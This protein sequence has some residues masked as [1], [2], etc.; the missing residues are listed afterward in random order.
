MHTRESIFLLDF[1]G[2]HN[3]NDM[4]ALCF[5]A[6]LCSVLQA[7]A[8][9]SKQFASFKQFA[10][11]DRWDLDSMCR[12]ETISRHL[13]AT[14]GDATQAQV[15]K[16]V[17]DCLK[18]SEIKREEAVLR[19]TAPSRVAE[20]EQVDVSTSETHKGV[21]SASETH[22]GIVLS[23]TRDNGPVVVSEPPPTH[24]VPVTP[25]VIP[26][27]QMQHQVVGELPPNPPFVMPADSLH[28][29]QHHGG[30]HA[31][32]HVEMDEE[33]H[34]LNVVLSPPEGTPI[35]IT[36]TPEPGVPVPP[37]LLNEPVV[38]PVSTTLTNVGTL[39]PMPPIEVT[40]PH[41]QT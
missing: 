35:I 14:Y 4:R 34:K 1:R 3:R 13:I 15:D 16:A 29:H 2:T 39:P 5:I 23:P 26:P 18:V 36:N 27:V 17:A 20:L 21:V 19:L 40:P 25:V 12:P 24:V 10:A 37:V 28:H 6:A 41:A 33:G 32:R 31:H 30:N 38:E 7:S 22:K 8:N 9:P 11:A